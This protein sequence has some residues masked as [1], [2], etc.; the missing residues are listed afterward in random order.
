MNMKS[1]AFL[2]G[3]KRLD[4]ETLLIIADGLLRTRPITHSIQGLGMTLGPTTQH[5]HGTIEAVVKLQP[6]PSTGL[7]KRC[8]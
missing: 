8:S 4:S 1:S 7:A 5:P 6:A 2:I 3:K